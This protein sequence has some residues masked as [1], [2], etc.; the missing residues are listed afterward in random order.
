MKAT[1]SISIPL[2]VTNEGLIQ[3]TEKSTIWII[4]LDSSG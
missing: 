1:F 4:E 3:V 2:L